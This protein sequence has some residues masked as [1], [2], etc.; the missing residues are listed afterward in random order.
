MKNKIEAD[1]KE[2]IKNKKLFQQQVNINFKRSQGKETLV[3]QVN[4]FSKL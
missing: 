4:I 2:A 3:A 1:F